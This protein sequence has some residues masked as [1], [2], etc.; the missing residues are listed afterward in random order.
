MKRLLTIT[1][2]LLG[3]GSLD[4]VEHRVDASTLTGKVMCGYQGWFSCEGDGNQM[5]WTHWARNPRKPFAPENVTVDLWP[6]LAEFS[7]E[8][9]Y[10]TGFT[11]GDGR[12]AEVFSS[13]NRQTVLRHFQWMQTY[14]ID[15]VFAQR[16]ANGLKN[17]TLKRQKDTVLENVRQGADQYGRVFAVMYDLSG[18]R[19]GQVAHVWQDWSELR[20]N[21]KVTNSP[22]YLHHEGKPLVAV[23]GVGFSD[24]RQYSLAECHELVRQLKAD[25][26]AVMLGVPSWWRE[27]IRDAVDDPALR[28]VL[29]QA[30]VLSPWTI[31][32]YQTPQEATRHADRVWQPDQ[33]WCTNR[34]IDFLPVV[35]PGFSWHNLKGA[36]LDAIPRLK[37]E[38]LWSQIVSAQRIGSRMIYVAMFDEVDEGTAIFK[39]SNDPPTGN[40]GRFLTYEG[41][42]SDH[43]LRLVGE[44]SKLLR[45]EVPPTFPVWK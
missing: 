8:E 2:F 30:D 9:K 1:L 14:G 7:P 19:A 32:R 3:A 44:A 18:L 28:E 43:Y 39:C 45:G 34:E 29:K 13:T 6:D 23:W 36:P 21:Q 38:F 37:G 22:G 35:Y 4:A 31:G 25:G 15:G 11:H 33:K 26:C 41:L 5:G 10:A 16:F 42:P 12:V 27:G 40:G 24:D 20:K 17:E